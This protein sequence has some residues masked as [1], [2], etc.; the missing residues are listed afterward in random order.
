MSNDI[1]LLVRNDKKLLKEQGKIKIFRLIAIGS[2][3]VLIL[4]SVIIP[5]LNQQLSNSSI[6]KDREAILSEMLPFREKEAKLNVVNNRI[7]NI[8]KVLSKRVDVYEIVNKIL[9]I[10]PNEILVEG[11]EFTERKMTIKL[12]SES[13]VPVD[14]LINNL[15]DIAITK[16]SLV[17]VDK[18]TKR[19]EIIKGLSLDSLEMI[20]SVGRYNVSINLSI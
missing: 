7:E 2:L 11:I 14:S 16:E 4:I 18:K 12:S 9:G 3:V 10:V 6:E 8:S 15:V 19:K 17:P 1:N 20:E 13:L 5:I